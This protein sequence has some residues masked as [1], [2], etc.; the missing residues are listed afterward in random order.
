MI[1]FRS[2]QNIFRN[3]PLHDHAPEAPVLIAR[4]GI[5]AITSAAINRSVANTLLQPQR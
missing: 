1:H 5:D 2:E 3:L 4:A